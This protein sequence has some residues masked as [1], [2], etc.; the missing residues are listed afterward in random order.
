MPT[1][2]REE[3]AMSHLDQAFFRRFDRVPAARPATHPSGRKPPARAATVTHRG[4]ARGA[5]RHALALRLWFGL[6]ALALLLTALAA[7]RPLSVPDEGRYADISRW[8]LVSGDWL[9]PR[10]DDLPFFQ[11]PPL[12]HWLQAA[13]MALFGVHPWVARLPGIALALLMIFM[14]V[15]AVRRMLGNTLAERAALMLGTSLAILIGAP[16]VNH[17]IGVAAWISVAIWAFALAFAQGERP[18]AGW[19]RAGF[20]ACA[21]GLLTKGLIGVALPALVLFVWI[22]WTRQWRKV[23]RLPWASGLALFALVALPWFV[24]V[25]L[26]FPGALTYLFWVQ[27]FD[28]YVGNEFNNTQPW[29]FYLADLTLLLFPWS[30]FAVVEIA[31]SARP[32]RTAATRTPANPWKALCWIWLAVVVAFFSIPSSKLIGY[33]FPA[34][35]PLALLAAFGWQ[36]CLHGRRHATRWFV[37][38]AA[39]P[40]LTAV[41]L[42]PLYPAIDT[43]GTA[44]EIGLELRPRLAPGDVVLV[45]GGY[46]FDLP[47]VARMRT[48]LVVLQDWPQQRKTAGDVWQRELFEAGDFEPALAA[49]LLRTPDLLPKAALQPHR[50]LVTRNSPKGSSPSIPPAWH[51]VAR[52]RSWTLYRSSPPAAP[53]ATARGQV[54]EPAASTP[55][56]TP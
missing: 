50:W 24:W 6:C 1:G 3:V 10:L 37:A 51:E 34:L 7:A 53:A 40:V 16:Y 2:A 25:G 20:L 33:A 52:G 44:H 14:T 12:T 15:V 29:W 18:H 21:L 8:M 45:A 11:K 39:V 13:S 35:P 32:G 9:V 22:T 4:H 48:P 56:A 26:H 31:R 38:L 42:T 43:H 5:A 54:P 28:R 47:F 46:P 49:R 27:Q 19:A 23:W 41:V 17:D 30:L 36:R 55:R